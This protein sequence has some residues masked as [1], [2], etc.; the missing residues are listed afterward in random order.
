MKFFR[1]IALPAAGFA[2]AALL[3]VTLAACT[4]EQPAAPQTQPEA[5][6][7]EPAAMPDNHDHPHDADHDAAHDHD[8]DAADDHG[9]DH[10]AM[11]DDH[12]HDHGGDGHEVGELPENAADIMAAIHHNHT[13]LETAESD[14]EVLAIHSEPVQIV[15]LFKSLRDKLE[16]SE[17][18]AA[19]YD[20]LYTRIEKTAELMDKYVHDG[21]A[22]MVRSLIERINPD[23]EALEQL[24]D[25][26]HAHV[27]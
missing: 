19:E 5:P 24:A 13:V 23:I 2:F 21:N 26:G 22:D 9:H 8:H 14:A 15:A 7:A 25:P 17:E 4:A 12:G 10:D 20:T 11:A 18:Q 6:A 27:H 16:L 3:A 1:R